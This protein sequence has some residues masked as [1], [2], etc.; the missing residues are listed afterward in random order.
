MVGIDDAYG[1]GGNVPAMLRALEGEHSK[2]NV[3]DIWETLCHQGSAYPASFAAIPHLVRIAQA[4]SGSPRA[5]C[6]VLVGAIAASP[7]RSELEAVPL[8]IREAY[9][10]AIREAAEMAID[11]LERTSL[12]FQTFV[13]LLKALAGLKGCA[14][15]GQALSGFAVRKLRRVPELRVSTFIWP[16]GNRL[17]VTTEDP[18]RH[19]GTSWTAIT[20]AVNDLGPW[21]GTYT[22]SNAQTWLTHFVQIQNA[23][24][25][26][27]PPQRNLLSRIVR[28]SKRTDIENLVRLLP[29]LFGHTECPACHHPFVVIEILERQLTVD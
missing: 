13:Y 2:R 10:A 3:A 1:S 8:D 28:W 4:R 21:D 23:N 20:P 6:L 22:R 18:V 17:A 15:L 19:A 9:G 29:Y 26:R 27:T 25:T 12:D 16:R 24:G 5:E 14:G 11:M 7:T